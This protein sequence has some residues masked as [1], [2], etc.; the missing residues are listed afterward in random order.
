M[1]RAGIEDGV[2]VV[3]V[4]LASEVGAAAVV[5]ATAAGAVAATAG[6]VPAEVVGVR[7][8]EAA[9]PASRLVVRLVFVAFSRAVPR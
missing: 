5:A 7:V 6:V 2:S 1:V 3:A 4:V 8:G 9:G